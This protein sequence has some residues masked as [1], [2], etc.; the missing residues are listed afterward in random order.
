[1]VPDSAQYKPI[2]A[3]SAPKLNARILVVS[4]DGKEVSLPA[5]KQALDLEGTP[6]DVWIATEKP[7]GLT[8]DKLSQG[9]QGFY[10]GV[11]LTSGVPVYHTGS[12]WRT[13]LTPAEWEA[14]WA[15]EA[16]FKVRQVTWYAWPST[17]LG[18]ATS[19]GAIDTYTKALTASLTAE[20]AETFPELNP[21]LQLPIRE[22]YTYLAKPL[23]GATTPILKDGAG[24]ALMAVR[25]YRD[26]RENLAMTFDSNPFLTHALVLGPA[27]V[28]WVTRGVHLGERRTY[29][30]AQVDD[31]FYPTTL[32]GGSVHRLAPDD[33]AAAAAWQRARRNDAVTPDFRFDLVFNG[34][35]TT[36]AGDPLTEAAKQ[37]RGDFKWVS[38]TYTHTD[39]SRVDEATAEG[40]ATKNH[41]VAESL[42]LPGY[43]RETAVTG[44][45]SGLKNPAAM[46]GLFKAGVRFVVSDATRTGE[47]NPSPNTGIYNW[48]QPGILMIPR[49]RTNMFYNVES[50]DRWVDQYNA[51]YRNYWGKRLTYPELLD[52]ESDVLADHL[53]KGE[54]APWMFH[55]ANLEAYAEGKSIL[56]DLL[57]ATVAKYKRYRR[58]P[59]VSPTMAELGRLMANRMA[60]GQAGVTATL[61]PGVSLTLTAQEAATV[62]VT[63]VKGGTTVNYGGVSLARVTLGAGQTV[64]LPLATSKK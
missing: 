53:L 22:A 60:A 13:A 14:L 20:G 5:I 9:N 46:N 23:D 51:L 34:Q 52:K 36:A 29:L 26:G 57:D 17:D 37:L 64:T 59:I 55:Q 39:L 27:V 7:G 8:A 61:T 11:I 19:S 35:G 50:P 33:L 45:V 4:A 12:V 2:P 58:S 24:N 48:S 56:G 38:H 16:A 30:S 1:V 10:Q 18:F 43:A 44:M 42:G 49:R 63:G 31:V 47:D 28:E 3:P 32:Q 21:Q 62:A 54:F 15:Y 40:E 25:Q 41:A 6:Y